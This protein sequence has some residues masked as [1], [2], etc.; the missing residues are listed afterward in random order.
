MDK[1]YAGEGDNSSGER[2][3]FG[4]LDCHRT[5]F[6]LPMAQCHDKPPNRSR[7][8]HESVKIRFDS[9]KFVFPLKAVGLRFAVLTR[10]W[11]AGS[12]LSRNS[13]RE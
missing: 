9:C 8:R 2:D 4:D 3:D 13:V 6:L 7:S 11:A 10:A 12:V 5:G 1:D